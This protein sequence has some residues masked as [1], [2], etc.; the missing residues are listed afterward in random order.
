MV[1]VRA[2][3]V[4][5]I[6]AKLASGTMRQ[7]MPLTFPWTPGN[8]F[9]GTVEAV[10]AGVTTLR[11]GAEVYGTSS[12]GGAYAEYIV[13]QA[14]AVAEKPAALSLAQA[15]SV[16]VAALTAWQGLTRA[17]TCKPVK[18]CSSTAG[19]GRWGPTRCSLRTNWARTSSPPRSP[20]DLDFVRSLG[21]DEVIDYRSG[22]FET[23]VKD[24][25]V[26]FDLVGGDVQQR[27]YAVLKTGA[28]WWQQ[29]SRRQR[30]KP[31]GTRCTA[32]CFR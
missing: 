12:D 31:P 24:A 20:E 5:P 30:R 4:N 19:R 13:A 1:R 6:D 14:D 17:A 16:P 9:A 32:P 8:D 27:S 3:S 2:A 28:T 11:P 18:P 23:V 22:H 25:D 10:G 26:V 7:F 29:A 15:A 21:A